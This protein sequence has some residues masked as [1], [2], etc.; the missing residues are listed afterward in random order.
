[1]LYYCGIHKVPQLQRALSLRI[2][3]QIWKSNNEVTGRNMWYPLM[4][5]NWQRW[6]LT[7]RDFVEEYTP[8]YILFEIQELYVFEELHRFLRNT[9]NTLFYEEIHLFF[10]P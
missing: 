3:V 1:M 6:L 8:C 5:T 2:I 10:Q 9:L 4:R 7:V